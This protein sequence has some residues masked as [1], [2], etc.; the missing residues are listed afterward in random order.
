LCTRIKRITTNAV[1]VFGRQRA[2][3]CD[4]CKKLLKL[5]VVGGENLLLDL[6]GGVTR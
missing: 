5:A 6:G 4:K 1:G 3:F 2:Q